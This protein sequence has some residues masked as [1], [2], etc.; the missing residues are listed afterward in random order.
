MK[1]RSEGASETHRDVVRP[2][3]AI[4]AEQ[5]EEENSHRVDAR[6]ARTARYENSAEL[7]VFL[8]S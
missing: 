6:Y 1:L 4:G 2:C 7:Y 8:T 5:E 3:N